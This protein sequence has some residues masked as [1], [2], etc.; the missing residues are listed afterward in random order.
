MKKTHILAL[1]MVAV[2]IGVLVSLLGNFSRYEDFNSRAAK[3]GNEIV[4]AGKLVKEKPLQYNPLKDP[5]Y[6][7]FYIADEKGNQRM[8]EYKGAKPRDI[9]RS[10][11]IV[12][13]GHMEGEV[14]KA[15]KILMKCPSKYVENEMQKAAA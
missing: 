9:E 1:V 3:K 11:K 4:V 7:S 2:L 13:T 5:N 14:F 12:V 10:E 6:F 8:V 15:S